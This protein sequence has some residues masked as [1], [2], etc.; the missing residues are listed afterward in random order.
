MRYYL[1]C[2]CGKELVVEEGAAGSAQT[3]LCGRTLTVPSLAEL[4]RSSGLREPTLSPAKA[5]ETLVLA[6]KLPAEKQCLICG[7][8]TD[9][10]VR[11]MADCERAY[12]KAGRPWWQIAFLFLLALMSLGVL[13]A[14]VISR[15][16]D[17]EVHEFGSDIIL[18]VPL[19]VC[20]ACGQN[21]TEPDDLKAVM[22]H[23]PLYAELLDEFPQAH[24]HL[25]P[26][27]SL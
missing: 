7:E 20:K 22:R 12:V 26:R 15:R 19:R 1:D 21:L 25:A 6:G 8:P 9:A 2:S 16:A 27:F 3:C 4:R 17:D 18:P 13:A 24:V 14:G 5:I 23:V 10:V 11:C